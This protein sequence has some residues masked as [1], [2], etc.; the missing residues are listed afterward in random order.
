MFSV[1]SKAVIGH[2]AAWLMAIA[3]LLPPPK[4]DCGCECCKQGDTAANTCRSMKGACPHC[5]QTRRNGLCY[6]TKPQHGHCCAGGRSN[7][8]TRKKCC[9]RRGTLICSS[10]TGGPCCCGPTCPCCMSR[11]SQGVP[12]D[13]SRRTSDSHQR[14]QLALPAQ[15]SDVVILA[16]RLGGLIQRQPEPTPFASAQDRCRAL[17]RFTC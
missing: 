4:G 13:P 9:C 16:E 17:S 11:G 10:A 5:T 7:G 6:R 12:A 15:T 3:L 14:V 2:A 1:R 8:S